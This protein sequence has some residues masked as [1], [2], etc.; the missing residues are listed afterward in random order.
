MLTSLHIEN[1]AII[2]QLDLDFSNGFS[3]MTGET[4]AGKSIII[5]ALSLLCGARS[6]RDAI[7]SGERMATVQAVFEHCP[8]QVLQ[9]IA[10]ADCGQIDDDTVMLSRTVYLEGKNSVKCNGRSI[11][12]ALL[13]D[14]A[15]G[16]LQ[17]HGQNDNL[18]FLAQENHLAFL[19]DY[20][21]L[22]TQCNAYREKYE[23]LCA[24][25][26]KINAH[27]R[28]EKENARRADLLRYQISEI[29]AVKPKVGEEEELLSEK[30]KIQNAE[31]I[32]QCF[33]VVRNAWM[34]T[35]EE[36]ICT[37][38]GQAETSITQLL[39][40]YP[41][42]SGELQRLGAC[43]IEL[44]DIMQSV[45]SLDEGE[46]EVPSQQRLDEIE[47]RL[48][49][50]ARLKKKYG[51]DISQVLV[52]R[53]QCEQQ[54]QSMQLGETDIK[55]LKQQYKEIGTQALAMAKQLTQERVKYGK[56]LS[57]EMMRE[58]A[59]LDME[60][61]RF[62]VL[63]EPDCDEKGHPIFNASGTDRVQFLISTNPGE[64]LKP[65]DKVASG[66][67]LSRVMLAAKCVLN[68]EDSRT[69]IFDEVDTGVSGKTSQKIGLKMKQLS[70]QGCQVLCVTH[71][72]QIAALADAHYLISKKEEDGR[73]TTQVQLLDE[74][75][76]I[77]EL[78][79]ILGGIHI[80]DI[81]RQTA[82]EMLHTVASTSK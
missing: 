63:V 30:T 58:L 34:P 29:D 64:P 23:Q 65:I 46:S 16:L 38:L 56:I 26:T 32:E 73:T 36:D 17:I 42:L 48:G 57:E 1:I 55:Q 74:S 27:N 15:A 71:A 39:E 78:S 72:A 40:V 82:R 20:A 10:D 50:F 59:Y 69:M 11:S 44:E 9:L 6:G 18:L 25:K 80:T 2:K 7:R 14:I 76:R 13:R 43:R 41:S 28:D 47:A 8:K 52:F 22:T 31:K 60:K 45:L 12:V 61:V 66:G 49:E 81:V 75:G 21:Q 51:A 68:K 54:L 24:I 53:E 5:D 4:G 3:V 35:Q 77:E 79:R 37:L 19:D 33:E 62:S 67:E 70:Q